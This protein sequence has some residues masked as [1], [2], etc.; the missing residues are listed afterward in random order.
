MWL[1]GLVALVFARRENIKL[2]MFGWPSRAYFLSSF[3]AIF[4]WGL[5]VLFSIPFANY[6]GFES[7]RGSLPNAINMLLSPYFEITISSIFIVQSIFFGLTINAVAALG[8]ELMWRGYLWE[9]MKHLGFVKASLIIGVIWGA[10]HVPMVILVGHNYPDSPWLG[11]LLMVGVS[12]A[13]TPLLTYYRARGF[14]VVPVA[15]FHGT[16]NAT[17]GFAEL[18]FD[19]PNPLVVGDTGLVALFVFSIFSCLAICSIRKRVKLTN[20][21]IQKYH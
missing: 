4:I 15:V 11:A 10:W 5:I 1:P 14:S 12:V 20:N 8:E 17:G 7:L 13:L 18:L 3:K 6:V 21:G 19:K 2:L 16:V 9:K